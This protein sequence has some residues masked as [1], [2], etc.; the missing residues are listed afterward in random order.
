MH[1]TLQGMEQHHLPSEV[2]NDLLELNCVRTACREFSSALWNGISQTKILYPMVYGRICKCLIS[3]YFLCA[4]HILH[5]FAEHFCFPWQD[6]IIFS[7][8]CLL[9]SPDSLPGRFC[10]H[11]HGTGFF[12]RCGI[13]PM[14]WTQFW[15]ASSLLCLSF[16]SSPLLRHEIN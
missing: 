13:S 1:L 12:T 14:N 16:P 9:M 10:L 4:A 15:Y 2:A 5:C 6:A 7:T 3:L 8:L 11:S